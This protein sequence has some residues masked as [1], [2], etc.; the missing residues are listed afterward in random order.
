MPATIDLTGQT[1]G[2]LTV[3]EMVPSYRRGT[4]FRCCC[5]CGMEK[6]VRGDHLRYGAIR[7]CGC[8]GGYRHGLSERHS[9]YPTWA[10]MRQR[11]LN[12][13]NAAYARYGGRGITV[14]PRWDDFA[15]FLADMGEKPGPNYSIDRIDND[16]PYS[17]EN[18]RWAT[19]SEQANNRRKPRSW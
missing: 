4:Y 5:I 1:F 10:A 2:R 11:C 15:R 13:S 6:T 7:S 16:G 12:P 17:P 3:A 18:C 8:L 19:A 9:L 14:D